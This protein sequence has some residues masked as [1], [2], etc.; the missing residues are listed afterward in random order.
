MKKRELKQALVM[1]GTAYAKLEEDLHAAE[2][3]ESSLRTYIN[4]QRSQIETLKAQV[5]SL[6]ERVRKANV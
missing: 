6:A 2:I 3:R 1:A 5:D 4:G